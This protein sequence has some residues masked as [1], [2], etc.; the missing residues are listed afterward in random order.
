[1]HGAIDRVRNARL[2][3]RLAGPGWYRLWP[4]PTGA[5]MTRRI[6]IIQGHP[7]DQGDHFC[8]ALARAY[9]TGAEAAGHEVDETRIARLDFPVL[10]DPAEWSAQPAP[11]GLDAVQGQI[12]RADHLVIIFPLWLGTMPA[13][14]KAFF[15]QVLRPGFAFDEKARNGRGERLL[16]G[17]SARVIITMGMP[18]LVFRVFFGGHGYRYLKRNILQFCGIRPVRAS[19]VGM[20]AGTS[21]GRRDKWLK[22]V[23]RLAGKGI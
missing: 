1:L 9:R 6:L 12:R 23:G 5:D 21:P 10:T 18:A 3:S 14:V 15:E 19:L 17:K 4:I 8:H 20:V 2:K 7:H 13:L 11:E 16:K 22:R